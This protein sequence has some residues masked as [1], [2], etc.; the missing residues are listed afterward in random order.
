MHEDR[1]RATG[2]LSSIEY[3][4]DAPGEAVESLFR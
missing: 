3:R 2:L 4:P 1:I